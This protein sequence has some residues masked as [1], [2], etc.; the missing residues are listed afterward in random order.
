MRARYLEADW[1]AARGTEQ[2]AIMCETLASERLQELQARTVAG[3]SLDV[4]ADLARDYAA[5]AQDGRLVRRAL[6]KAAKQGVAA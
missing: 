4:V 6:A 2:E 5:W 1:T 3:A